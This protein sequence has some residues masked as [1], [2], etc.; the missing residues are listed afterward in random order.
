MPMS[1]SAAPELRPSTREAQGPWPSAPTLRVVVAFVVLFALAVWLR[2]L[3]RLPGTSLAVVWPAAAVGFVWTLWAAHR[4][5]RVLATQALLLAA[6]AGAVN[7]A[8]GALPLVAVALGVANALQGLVESALLLRWRPDAW[9]LRRS[10]DVFVLVTTSLLGA[11]AGAAIG[12]ALLIVDGQDPA[13]LAVAWTLRNTA[14]TFVFSCLVL[15]LAGGGRTGEHAGG[16]WAELGA[17]GLV[18]AAVYPLV[19][20][21]PPDCTCRSSCC[22]CRCGSRCASARTSPRRTCCSA[23]CSSSP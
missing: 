18:L 10:S 9:R 7:W 23:P 12:P 8:T 4:G 2:R 3:S 1:P 17:A 5:R 11:L 21:A 19:F 15:R 22:R 13:A 6:L 16:G 14:N 20:G